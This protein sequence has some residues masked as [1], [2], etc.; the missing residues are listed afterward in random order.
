MLELLSVKLYPPRLL[1][2]LL[3]RPRLVQ[4]LNHA[5]T[6]PLT[7][8]SAPAGFG[9]ST[10]LSQWQAQITFPTG[11]LSLDEQDNELGVFAAFFV[12]ALQS[13]FPNACQPTQ[14]LL[15]ASQLPPPEYMARQLKNDIAELSADFVLILDDYHLL[16]D[17]QVLEFMN[18]LLEHQPAQ[19]HLILATRVSPALPLTR[20]R[21][22]GQLVELRAAD[23]RFAPDEA[24]AFLN[25]SSSIALPAET[26][27]LIQTSVEGWA[28]GLRLTSISLR[29]H[30]DP[31]QYADNFRAHG[32]Q[33]I[34]DY[35][36]DEVLARQSSEVQTFLLQ[37]SLLDTF[38]AELCDAM[39]G[40]ETPGASQ[41]MI[42]HLRR[43]NLF[44]ITLDQARGWYRYHH[45]FRDLLAQR[46]E[47]ELDAQCNA[48]LHA[49]ASDWFAAH[50]FITEAI[51][52]ALA[53]GL[54]LRAAEIV[55]ANMHRALNLEQQRV[56]ERWL[57][58]LPPELVETR[59]G[60]LI[61]RIYALDLRLRPASKQELLN[62]V[63]QLPPEADAARERALQGDILFFRAQTSYW[64]GE[65]PRCIDAATRALEIIPRAHL[66]ARSNATMFLGIAH[67]IV[68]EH[69]QAIQRLSN[70]VEQERVQPSVITLRS[71][72]GLAIISLVDA[73][74][75]RLQQ[76]AQ[77]LLWN[78][79]QQKLSNSIAWAHYMLGVLH[80][81]WNE[82]DAATQH[83]ASAVQMRYA[84]NTRVM[85]EV[86]TG[87]TLSYQARGEHD[88]AN[89][90][91]T[92]LIEFDRAREFSDGL[93]EAYSLQAQLALLQGDVETAQQHIAPPRTQ[94]RTPLLW[95]QV[96]R[97]TEI[98]ILL[99]Q[100]APNQIARALL[101]VTPLLEG[102]IQMH[103]KRRTIH[104]LAL[105]ALALDAAGETRAAL[106]ALQRSLQLAENGGFIRTYVDLGM[107]M[108]K[109][110]RQI[111]SFSP[112][113]VKRILA[114]FP[115]D[116]LTANTR[117]HP[118]NTLIE[119]LTTREM[120]VLELLA[121]RL[122]DKEIAAELV[123]SKTTAKSHVK[124]I[125]A[126]LG[127]NNRRAAVETAR[128]LSILPLK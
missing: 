88:N 126:K 33:F 99:A 54:P 50:E 95:I 35:L 87:L 115:S 41:E 100:G 62:R 59:R 118:T 111:E 120:Q 119:P 77:T 5:L 75:P 101:G 73:D 122:T 114:Q 19:L 21:A 68:G 64:H 102:A 51:Q 93:E 20:L 84:I 108:P 127:V 22:R 23:L 90:T 38:T 30:A 28:A 24:E 37:T 80:Y 9:K 52:H 60:L 46:R 82:L 25:Q 92:A 105:Q 113:Y 10:L 112:R 48:T 1:D 109:L 39:T 42:E 43:A 11:W 121:Q 123:I 61:A 47:R 57:K 58:L 124:H 107:R 70:A 78:A 26:L 71:F 85:H 63:E 91:A 72:L 45:L 44:L 6:A 97:A 40:A 116:A 79:T 94:P 56:L 17:P 96:S 8:V 7:L 34:M 3:S 12:G 2:D 76:F 104:F 89:E 67:H 53:A 74:L 36:L 83:F 86:M 128:A 66:F 29:G 103:D 31:T 13:I 55:E 49:R 110:L 18:E 14:A 15:Q 81:E 65:F 117:S 106:E 98:L 16:T 69:A 125:L 32:D 27:T 4:Q